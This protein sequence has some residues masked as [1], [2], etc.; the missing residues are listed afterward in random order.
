[1]SPCKRCSM[2][3]TS[4]FSLLSSLTAALNLVCAH[5]LPGSPSVGKAALAKINLKAEH[6]SWRCFL[7][8]LCRTRTVPAAGPLRLVLQRFR[9]WRRDGRAELQLLRA[10][11]HPS[12]A[13]RR[14]A[15]V[16]RWP[17]DRLCL[18]QGLPKRNPWG[19]SSHRVLKLTGAVAIRE[20]L[21]QPVD[22]EHHLLTPAVCLCTLLSFNFV[23]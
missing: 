21:M 3:N 2:V 18:R 16:P 6:I 7:L 1:M 9:V 10:E 15:W 11:V 23:F 14:G 20:S 12:G 13:L 5:R 8:S 19:S 17:R 22:D 4:K